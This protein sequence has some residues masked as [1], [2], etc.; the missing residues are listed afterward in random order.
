MTGRQIHPPL[1]LCL[2]LVLLTLGPLGARTRHGVSV[3]DT[4]DLAGQTLPL[5]GTGLRSK[6][7]FKVYVGA[8]YCPAGIGRE[9][10]LADGATPRV[11]RM[12]YQFRDVPKDRL[13]GG[14]RENFKRVLGDSFG[15]LGKQIEEYLGFFKRD[16]V[17]GDLLEIRY[18]PPLESTEIAL[19]GALL[20]KIKSAPFAQVLWETWFGSKPADGGLK[21]DL[22]TPGN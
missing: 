10:Q 6:F 12:Y 1:A 13:T 22:L 8:L 14:F 18:I 9:E 11:L 20:G 21:K 2:T 3:A 4:V 19:N 7:G 5:L 15:A 17:P 16:L